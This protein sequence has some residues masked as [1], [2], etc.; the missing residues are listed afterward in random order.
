MHLFSGNQ[1]QLNV[2][3]QLLTR[4]PGLVEKWP[5]MIVSVPEE[6]EDV[7]KQKKK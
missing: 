5:H 1:S 7:P 2:L 6:D 4:T 3:D